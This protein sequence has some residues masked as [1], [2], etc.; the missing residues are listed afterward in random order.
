MYKTNRQRTRDLLL[1]YDEW[2]LPL[3]VIQNT[4]IETIYPWEGMQLTILSRTLYTLAVNSGYSGSKEEFFENF[5]KFI[6]QAKTE[7]VFAT[8]ATFPQIGEPGVLYF[9]TEEKI[10]YYWDDGYYPVSATLI[11]NTLLNGGGA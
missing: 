2:L 4:S 3:P 6:E 5:G 9:D 10:I 8:W 1:K 7:I 11:E